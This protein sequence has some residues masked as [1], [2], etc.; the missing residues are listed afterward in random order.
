VYRK[1]EGFEK[2]K[3]YEAGVLLTRE[4]DNGWLIKEFRKHGL[5][6]K[7]FRARQFTEIYIKVRFATIRK[8]IH[9]FNLM[10]FSRVKIPS[11]AFGT[12]LVFQKL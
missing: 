8:L 1:P 5:Q 12:L 3:E 6:L 2:W 9:W 11:L 7:D 4:F 10:W